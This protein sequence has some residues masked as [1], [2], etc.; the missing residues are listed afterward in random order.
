[1]KRAPT[2]VLNAMNRT[3]LL[4]SWYL[5]YRIL[6]WEDAVTLLWLE[7]AE[8]LIDYDEIVR[9]PSIAMKLPA[10]LR[11]RRGVGRSKRSVRFSRVNVFVRDGHRCQYCGRRFAASALTYDHV[12]PRAAGGR[13]EWTNIVTAC[14]PCNAQKGARTPDA[15]GMFP[16][17]RP[18][19]PAALP[20]TAVHIDA[21]EAPREWRPFVG[22]E[23]A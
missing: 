12:L 7:K 17:R 9:S 21:T 20:V 11:L 2:K 14:R 22:A 4:T 19:A 1:M 3:L 10:V 16:L 23:T 15:S 13:T 18:V 8:R 6:R 5:P